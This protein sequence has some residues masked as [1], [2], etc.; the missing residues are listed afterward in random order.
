MKKEG[1]KAPEITGIDQFGNQVST[2]DFKGKKL[3]L[4]FYP[5][6][7]TP[8]CTAE[9]CNLRDN[10][11]LLKNKGFSILGV[12]ADGEAKHKKFAEK[13]NLP[14]QLLADTDKQVIEAFGAWGPKKFMGKEYEGIL[15]ST[16]VIDENGV[17]QKVFD[18][19]KTKD[20]TNQILSALED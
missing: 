6:D 10:Y 17:I 19:V 8:G 2:N 14:F 16:F 3:V 9:A 12:S 20:H 7:D 11:E 15:R 4:Y 5:K 1:E 18:K 13:Y